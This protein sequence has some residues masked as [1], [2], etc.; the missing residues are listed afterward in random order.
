MQRV[1]VTD[2]QARVSVRCTL[3][4]QRKRNNAPKN[5]Q[6]RS[7][8]SRTFRRPSAL[9]LRTQRQPA[10]CQH[11]KGY[12]SSRALIA[13]GGQ[14]ALSSFMIQASAVEEAAGGASSNNLLIVG[15][16]VLGSLVGQ[17]WLKLFP[18][19]V[20]TGQTNTTTRHSEL[21]DLGIVPRTKEE[22]GEERFPYVIFCAP[23]SGSTDYVGEVRGA[24][25]KWDGT[26]G[27][28]FTSSTGV[29]SN[30]TSFVYTEESPTIPA[31]TSP[32]VDKLLDAEAAVKECHGCVVRLAGLY[33]AQRGAHMYY[34]G[35]EEVA[36]R[37]DAVLNLLHYEDAASISCSLLTSGLRE[38]T[39]LGCDNSPITKAAIM[40]ATYES[41]RYNFEGRCKF[42]ATEGPIGR[43]MNNDASRQLL[44][45]T[46]KYSSY[47]EFMKIHAR[48]NLSI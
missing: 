40:D 45:W 46:P 3:D 42:T 2:A 18:D 31:G 21:K 25:G 47:Q 30:D 5:S 48:E 23:P 39:V 22:A 6:A 29:Y 13:P 44:G 24:A 43:T 14:R 27:L 1:S 8:N 34:G 15:P 20:V 12:K 38:T 17:Q 4:H 9:T 10:L 19:A 41:G 26:G 11:F 32:R 35:Q 36:G 28:V 16:G 7:T 37:P 33:H